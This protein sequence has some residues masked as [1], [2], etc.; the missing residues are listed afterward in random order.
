[1]GLFDAFL[2]RREI[3]GR[4]VPGYSAYQEIPHESDS[5]VITVDPN[6]PLTNFAPRPPVIFT[7][8]LE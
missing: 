1:M 4:E 6:K 2:R 3:P 8:G 5:E 7:N